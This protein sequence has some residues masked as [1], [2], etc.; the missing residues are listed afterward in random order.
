[1]LMRYLIWL[2]SRPTRAQLEASKRHAA[3]KRMGKLIELRAR[4]AEQYQR[5]L[6]VFFK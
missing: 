4:N 3:S 2:D 1:M 6:R 5:E